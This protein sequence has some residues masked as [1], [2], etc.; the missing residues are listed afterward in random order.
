MKWLKYQHKFSSGRG[1][2]EWEELDDDATEESVRDDGILE[3][4]TGKYDYS[5]KYGGVDF[6]VVDKAPRWVLEKELRHAAERR[7]AAE[8]EF[9]RFTSAMDAGQYIACPQCDSATVATADHYR[10]AHVRG[11][12]VTVDIKPCPSCG[13]EVLVDTLAFWLMPDDRD[14]VK[15]LGSLVENGKRSVKSKTFRWP[16]KSKKEHAAYERLGKLGL[17]YGSSYQDVREIQATQKGEAEWQKH[18][19]VSP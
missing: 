3:R 6:E 11:S 16:L 7:R 18:K 12:S 1:A 17:V 9:Q 13:R 4:L 15:L 14:A 19:T 10:Q 8:K 2:W 5:D